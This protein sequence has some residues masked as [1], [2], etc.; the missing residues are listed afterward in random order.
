MYKR[1][2][3]QPITTGPVQKVLDTAYRYI[4]TNFAK[5]CYL[6]DV[7]KVRKW[8]KKPASDSQISFLKKKMNILEQEKINF[9]EMTKY[10]ASILIGRLVG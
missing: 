8:G 4:T 6:W 7:A 10:E 1:K 5:S 2:L 3:Y 9:D